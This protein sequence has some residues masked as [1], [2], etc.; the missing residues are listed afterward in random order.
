LRIARIAGARLQKNV[1]KLGQD[2]IDVMKE[3]GLMVH[4]VPEDVR[5]HWERS[6]RSGYS[7]LV[8]SY[9]SP[10]MLAEVERLRDEYRDL[11]KKP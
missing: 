2:A 3:H 5:A 11:H 10:E 9:V 4:R 7:K 6:A 8:G 1:R